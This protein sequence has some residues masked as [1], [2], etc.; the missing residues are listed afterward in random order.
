MLRTAIVNLAN[1]PESQAAYLDCL[2]APVTGGASA[3]SYGNDELAL[4]FEDYFVTVQHMLST[5]EINDSQ[6]LAAKPLQGMLERWSGRS[7]ADF[8]TRRALFED[9][10]WEEVRD[11][12]RSI[13]KEFPD[14]T[15]DGGSSPPS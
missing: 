7:N 12:A 6:A 10:R 4:Q 8:W 14:E 15:R 2:L 3:E 5:G 1:P 11:C 9:P 13:L